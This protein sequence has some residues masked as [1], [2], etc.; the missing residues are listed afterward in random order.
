M[1]STVVSYVL[2]LVDSASS[3]MVK[4]PVHELRGWPFSAKYSAGDFPSKGGSL[5][6]LCD[7][8]RDRHACMHVPRRSLASEGSASLLLCALGLEPSRQLFALTLAA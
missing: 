3:G 1:F 4:H 7:A 8:G 2:F 5:A 6:T